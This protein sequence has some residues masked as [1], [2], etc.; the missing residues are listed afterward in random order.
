MSVADHVLMVSLGRIPDPLLAEVISG[1]GFEVFHAKSLEEAFKHQHED[2]CAAVAILL[3][4]KTT[5][6]ISDYLTTAAKRMPSAKFIVAAN[7]AFGIGPR[8]IDDTLSQDRLLWLQGEPCA[9]SN[10]DMLRRFLRGEGYRWASDLDGMLTGT[11]LLEPTSRTGAE[12]SDNGKHILRFAGDLSRFTELR[13]MLD[14]ALNRYLQILRCGAGSIYLWDENDKTLVLEAAKGPDEEKRLGIRQKLSEGL[15]GRVAK[16]G[17]PMLVT[18]SRKVHWL[19]GRACRRYSNFSVI[20]LPV[21]HGGQLFGVVCLTEPKGSAMFG[22]EDLRLA[23]NLA[24]KLASAVRPL[25]VLSELRRFSERLLGAFRSSSDMVLEK[26]AEVEALRDL[27]RKILDNVPLGVI[28]YDRDLR[29]RSSNLAARNLFG[30]PATW[31]NGNNTAPLEQGIEM[32][33]AL[34]QGKLRDVVQHGRQFRLQRVGYSVDDQERVLDIH[35]RP[36]ETQ[37]GGITVGILTVQDV[38]EDVEMENKL[39]SAERLA[40]VGKIAAKVAHELNNPLDGIQR[41]LNLAIRQIAQPEKAKE[42][43]D[44][45]RKGLLR[46]SHI[47][48]ELLAF[49]RSHY[50]A[51]RPASLSQVVH[52][53]LALYEPRAHEANIR[54]QTDVPP[55]LP[56]CP[57]NE[58]WEVFG[59]VVKNALDAMGQNG[60]LNIT[61]EAQADQVVITATDTGPGVPPDL[62][63]KIFEPFFT[64]KKEGSGTGLGLAVC[65]D[66]MR[67]IGGDIRLAECDV[68]ASFQILVP[69]KHQTE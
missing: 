20:A 45:S 26:D 9:T 68:G 62:R 1:E 7:G 64:T 19:R 46:M 57:S 56:I 43:L 32:D 35:C 52:Q 39:Q 55:N 24:Q 65:R 11:P 5:D 22:P 48:S 54:I 63:E 2:V 41:F 34:W 59:N 42:Y 6:E 69:T 58:V 49:S 15:A 30:P 61:A 25:T 36:L 12:E 37:E 16:V 51:H 33:N 40:I 47:L 23:Q 10:V 29:I 66:A 44:E 14:E 28:A 8:N 67:R 13:P 18:D 60:T 17:E 38:T 53:G 31:P 27:S 50:S 4:D 3:G 21:M